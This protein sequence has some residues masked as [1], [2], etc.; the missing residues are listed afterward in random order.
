[1]HPV[2]DFLF[3]YYRYSPTRLE[4]WHPG[5][6]VPLEAHQPYWFSPKQYEFS[7][8]Q[9]RCDRGRMTDEQIA[10]LA[11]IR[12]LLRSTAKRRG[13]FGC[14]GM[15]EWAMVYRGEDIRHGASTPLRLPQSE[16][17]AW[18]ESR[19]ICCSHFDAFRFFATAARPLNRWQLTRE[20]RENTEQPACLHANMD[21]YKW[22][23]QA[24]PW[25][26]S[27]LLGRCFELAVAAR[28]IDMRASPYDLSQ[29]PGFPPIR[30]ETEAG[31]A[32]YEREQRLLAAQAQP[33]RDALMTAIERVLAE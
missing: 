10:R 24:M 28:A 9:I 26:G 21:L 27:E 5:L 3:V 4:Q 31:R 17:D 22:A 14:L 25:I 1:V 2:H 19:P 11:W 12:D 29:Y 6:G 8:N 13:N 7:G 23:Y 16:I 18:V 33:L 20:S 30:V 15:H 32:A